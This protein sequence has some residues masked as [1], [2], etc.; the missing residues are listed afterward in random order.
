MSM[1][2]Y[3]ADYW[4]N[5]DLYPKPGEWQVV[6]GPP[7]YVAVLK[8][9]L[10]PTDPKERKEIPIATGVLDYFPAALAEIAR[11][12]KVG[13]DQHNPGQPLHHA[14]GKSMDHADTTIRH[15]LERGTRDS[16]GQRHTAKAAWR[17]LAMLQEEC[18]RDGAPLARGARNDV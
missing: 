10:L 8:T 6:G 16:D 7:D 12:S 5:I 18:E 4:N 9:S 3:D 2:K 14:R 17:I 15:F 1:T 13:N 11:I